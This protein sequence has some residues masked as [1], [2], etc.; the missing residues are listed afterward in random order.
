MRLYARAYLN[1]TEDDL[2]TRYI[3]YQTHYSTYKYNSCPRMLT[4]SLSASRAHAYSTHIARQKICDDETMM[5]I[6]RKRRPKDDED[7]DDDDDELVISTTNQHK[8]DKLF[9]LNNS[10]ITYILVL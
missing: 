8:I 3:F 10:L 2:K 7:N 5:S 4:Y 6:R 9:F 1:N